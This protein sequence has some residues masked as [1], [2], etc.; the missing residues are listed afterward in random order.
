MTPPQKKIHR[1]TCQAA[2]SRGAVWSGTGARVL[3]C[4]AALMFFT[5]VPLLLFAESRLSSEQRQQAFQSSGVY[6]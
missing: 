1:D 6:P 5:V 4:G 2:R 3:M